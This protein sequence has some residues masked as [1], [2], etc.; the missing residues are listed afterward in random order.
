MARSRITTAV[1]SPRFGDDWWQR[2]VVYQIYPR[3]FADSDGDGD[4]RPPG[5]HRP[6]RPPRAGPASASTPSGCRRSTRRR[7]STSA[8]T[9]ATTTTVDPLFGTDDDFDRLVDEAHRRGHAGHPRPRHEPH[10]RPAPVVRGVAARRGRGRTPT[11]TCGATRPARRRRHGRMPPNNWVSF[12]GGPGWEWEPAREQFYFH[13]FLPEQPE[14]ELAQPGG[15]GRPAVRWS[16]AGWTAASTAS[17]STSST[18][19]SST[20]TCCRTRRATGRRPWDRQLHLYDSDQP[21]FPDL[22]ARFRAIVDE[23]AR[24]DVGRR[25][26][27]WRPSRPRRA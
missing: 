9:S 19:S 17:G 2:G 21:D 24:P 22:L 3:S 5:H 8:T 23:R 6:P 16:A 27:R 14:L 20:P 4:R 10:Q 7:G 15:R 26:V 13:T 12:F 25:A 18:R 1:Q 11:G